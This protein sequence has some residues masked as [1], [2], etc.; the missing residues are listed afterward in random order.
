MIEEWRAV[1]GYEGLYEV[2]DQGR[3]RSID[4]YDSIGRLRKKR[5]IKLSLNSSGYFLVGLSKR[6]NV[7][8]YLVH[9]LVAQTFIPNPLGLP[10]V[11]HK[12]ENKLNNIV[13]NLEW[14]DRKYNNNYGTARIRARDTAIKN[15]SWSGLSRKEYMKKYNQEN[16]E[17]IKEC[18]KKYNQE[19]KE[20]IKEYK[21]RYYQKNKDIFSYKSKEYR[22][23]HREH[24]R[25]MN[26][27]YYQLHR[28]D[29][30]K[31]NKNRLK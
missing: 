2:S 16:K 22:D 12:D 19:N 8:I 9:R 11:N 13:D 15:G 27:K 10:Q 25:E 28:E 26:R 24:I 3:V 29:I 20:Y 14:C 18:R 23:T 31:R 17:Y 6:G 21:K 30:K 7:T 1:P 5:Y 4:R